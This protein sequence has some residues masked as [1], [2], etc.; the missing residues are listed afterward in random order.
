M[1]F[2]MPALKG[3][4]G[5]ERAFFVVF[6]RKMMEEIAMKKLICMLLVLSLAAS[7]LA[8]CQ[9][10]ELPDID[11]GTDVTEASKPPSLEAMKE[12]VRNQ[13]TAY[14]DMTYARPDVDA[15]EAMVQDAA[16]AAQQG[17][18]E[19]TMDMVYEFYDGYDWFYTH[20]S[21][22]DIRYSGDL[23]DEYWAEEY[24]YCM[25]ASVRVDAALEDLYYTLAASPIL[26]ELE[27]EAYFG[28]GFFDAY[29]GENVWDEGY[30]ALLEQE[31]QLQNRYYELSEMALEYRYG[32]EEYMEA[33]GNEMVELMV[34]LI[35]LRQEIAAY[36]GYT[37]YVQFATD[38][39]YYRD[40]T[41]AQAMDY[42][43]EI[44]DELVP[45]YRQ[46]NNSMAFYI[47]YGRATEAQSYEYVRSMA[48][49]MGGTVADAFAR[50]D[51]AGLYDIRYSDNKYNSSFEVYLT[52]YNSPFVFMNPAGDK[53]D[54]LVLAHEF[55]HFCN[56][57][58]ARGCYAGIDV[59]EVFSQ[60]MEYLSLCYADGGKE[61]TRMKM[62]D[63]L[64]LFVEQSAFASFEMQMYGLTGEELNAENLRALYAR[65]AQEYGFDSVGYDDWEFV[66]I[67]HFYTS[68][69][70]IISYI[71]SNDTSMQ[72][73]QLELETEGMG[74]ACLEKNLDTD[75]YYFLEFVE[76]AGLV[77]PFAEGR[78]ATIR[79][80]LEDGLR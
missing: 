80:T 26:E 23:T 37:D 77:S 36:L 9:L 8:G 30:T 61:L 52:S 72:I 76:D 5:C 6:F 32:S 3:K 48:E 49:N 57:Y 66:G 54:H 20:L 29:Q 60:T 42:L 4:T 43:A 38:Y 55:G 11:V 50:L 25:E 73:Y 16:D 78:V 64:C 39:Y 70:Y 67:T 44:R 28:K 18:V 79:Q 75:C 40:Y 45:M 65:V 58:A 74:L 14:K 13:W 1:F 47:D 27:S 15:L 33:C 51:K 35:A 7:L 24:N 31:A 53:Y 12:Q 63:S 41:H 46:L 62:W 17:D 2:R 59:L 21:L 22:A 10:P 68:P 69:M 34:Q 19:L 56:D 71:V